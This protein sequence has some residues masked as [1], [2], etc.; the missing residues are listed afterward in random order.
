VRETFLKNTGWDPTVTYDPA[1]FDLDLEDK[2][3]PHLDPTHPTVL[4]DYPATAASLSQIKK[5]D[6]TIAE[7]AEVFIGGLEIVN[8]Y[9]ELTDPQEQEKRFRNDIAEIEKKEGRPVSIPQDF[10]EAIK[11]LP[12][13]GGIALGVDRLVMLLCNAPTIYDVLPFPEIRE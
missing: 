2:I 3:L 12:E 10:L 1:R 9:S 6:P 5:T 13:C 7:R 8:A 11:H 4:I